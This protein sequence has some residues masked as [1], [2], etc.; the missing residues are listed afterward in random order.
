MVYV[1]LPYV[2]MLFWIQLCTHTHIGF[3]EFDEYGV[4]M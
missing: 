3:D 2:G 4:Y 1:I